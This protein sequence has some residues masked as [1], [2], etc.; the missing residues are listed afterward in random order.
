MSGASFRC[1]HGC[2]W[3]REDGEG[4]NGGVGVACFSWS[5]IGKKGLCDMQLCGTVKGWDHGDYPA[6]PGWCAHVFG[7]VLKVGGG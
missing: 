5:P 6:P 7:P 2:W 3:Q 4:K 1:V